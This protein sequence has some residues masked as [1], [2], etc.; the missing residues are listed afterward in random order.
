MNAATETSERWQD[1]FAHPAY[2]RFASQILDPARTEAEVEGLERLVPIQPGTRVLDLG[3]GYGRFS[4]P[5]ARLGCD[6]TALDASC[7]QLE[8]A[9]A[10]AEGEGLRMSFVRADMR[11]L[12]IVGGFDVVLLL[13]TALGYVDDPDGDQTAVATAARALAPGGALVIDTEN[14]E[15]KLRAAPQVWF[16]MG[17]ALLWAERDY[18]HLTGRW[19]ERMEWENGGGRDVAE[20]RLWLY[21]AAELRRMLIAAGLTVDGLW[22]SLD[23]RPYEDTS[24]RTVLRAR[25]DEGG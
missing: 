22:G 3:C 18:D 23:G 17:E 10:A 25:K 16:R 8:L 21:T 14:R 4:L 11:D 5:L 9:R 24:P 6:V 15:P 19:T 1:F 7:T 2:V 12:D 20:Y 13:G